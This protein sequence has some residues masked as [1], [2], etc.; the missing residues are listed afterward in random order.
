MPI[1]SLVRLARRGS[2]SPR[3]LLAWLLGALLLTGL[4]HCPTPPHDADHG[5][6][7]SL[8]LAGDTSPKAESKDE[9]AD[10]DAPQHSHSGASCTS[11]GVVPQAQ[12]RANSP[13][14]V[15]VLLPPAAV[16]T[17]AAAQ[18]MPTPDRSPERRIA[19]PGRTT[20]TIV[21]RWRI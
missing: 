6:H 4:L 13:A 19:R 10:R 7:P 12:G 11:L 9:P 5:H 18:L 3:L 17:T 8:V 21:C 20:L 15:A 1:P 2:P 16:V 14:R